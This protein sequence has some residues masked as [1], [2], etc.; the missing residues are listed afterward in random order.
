MTGSFCYIKSKAFR[1]FSDAKKERKA[2]FLHPECRFALQTATG[3]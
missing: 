1:R 2:F 3:C